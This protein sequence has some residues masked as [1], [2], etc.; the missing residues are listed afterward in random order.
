MLEVG[1]LCLALTSVDD[2]DLEAPHFN[3][4]K[5]GMGSCSLQFCSL[6]SL[7]L[8]YIVAYIVSYVALFLVYSICHIYTLFAFILTI[9]NILKR[10]YY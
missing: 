6:R 7:R 2:E 8:A 1:D 5:A 9:Q 4:L 3:S 10:L